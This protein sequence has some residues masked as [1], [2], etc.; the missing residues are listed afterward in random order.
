MKKTKFVARTLTQKLDLSGFKY[1]P[2]K[3]K[4]AKK[5]ERKK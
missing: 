2:E 5:N 4:V 1:K 3:K